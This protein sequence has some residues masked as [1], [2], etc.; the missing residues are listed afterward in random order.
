MRVFAISN[1]APDNAKLTQANFPHLN[2]VSD[3]DQNVTKALQVAH[4][5]AGPHGQDTNAPT[6]ILVDGAGT[7]RWLFRPDRFFERLPPGELLAAIDAH[8][9]K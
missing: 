9:R 2:V 8:L 1:D 4:P 6:T 3:A 5:G 7:V